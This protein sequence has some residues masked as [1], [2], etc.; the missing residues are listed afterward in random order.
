MNQSFYDIVT[1]WVLKDVLFVINYKVL[2][3]QGEGK[4][5]SLES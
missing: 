2:K 1:T 4:Q 3:M 5:R